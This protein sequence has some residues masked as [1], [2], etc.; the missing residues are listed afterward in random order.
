MTFFKTSLLGLC[1]C[2]L[3]GTCQ[4]KVKQW[5]VKTEDI[6]FVEL[7]AQPK[8]YAKH[9]TGC[10]SSLSYMPDTNY[11]EHFP[12]RHIRVNMHFMNH[13]DSTK[14]FNE[15]EA[16]KFAKKYL[17]AA[18]H[19][20]NRRK[21]LAIPPNN[22]IPAL[23]KQYRYVLTPK[24]NDPN[25]T[26]VYCHYDDELFYFIN[27]GNKKNNYSRTVIEK[28]AIQKDS[29]LNMFVMPHHPDSVA[30]PTYKPRKTGIALNNHLKVSGIFE[31]GNYDPWQYRGLLNHEVGHVLGLSHAWG[32]DG[33]D[34][35]P[36][37]SNC[38]NTSDQPPCDT[39]ASNNVM[40]YNAHQ[41]AWTPCQIGKIHRNL[42]KLS[43]RQ[44]RLLI[45]TWCTLKPEKTITIRDNITWEGAKDL[46]GHIII[47]N[48]GVLRVNCRVS[49][50]Q[51]AKI[52]V[53]PSGKLILNN[54]AWLHNDCGHQWEGIE[55]QS[56]GKE[57]GVVVFQGTPAVENMRHFN[58]E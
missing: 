6:Q 18:E 14:N 25:D 13:S 44:R 39:M 28:Y 54:D 51:G 26:G 4:P 58:L 22:Q 48:G 37:H 17:K 5:F 42:S 46:E 45:R 43:A 57:K 38:W 23:P 31:S 12:M 33:C 7:A 19:D 50:P 30:S 29:V 10:N 41:S 8:D 15:A 36:I 1:C 55:I 16:F 9:K 52:T 49:L 35:T 24:R 32:Y 20:L 47:E 56:S 21:K 40:D 34:D 27:K 53:R 3:F 11:I 2:L